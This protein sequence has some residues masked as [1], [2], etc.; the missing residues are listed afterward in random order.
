LLEF[1]IH[2]SGGH[3]GF[4]DAPPVR[5]RVADWILPALLRS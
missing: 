1:Q 5:H 4:V 3:C 2:P